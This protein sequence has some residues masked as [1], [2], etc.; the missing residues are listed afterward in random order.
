MPAEIFANLEWR[1]IGE[2]AA[3][4]A[5]GAIVLFLLVRA[6]QNARRTE[7]FIGE[8]FGSTRAVVETWS[9]G[10]GYVRIAGELWKAASK[11]D[12]APGDSVRV[13]RVEGMLLRVVK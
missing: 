7:Y 10:A 11:S 3:M 12:F 8:D 4:L 9:G 1:T 6:T 13:A 5:G 2:H